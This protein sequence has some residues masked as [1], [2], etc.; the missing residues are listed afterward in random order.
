M[1]PHR[2]LLFS[3]VLGLSLILG[4]ASAQAGAGE[5]RAFFYHIHTIYSTDNPGWEM[6]KPSVAQVV[7][8]ADWAA[9]SMG[10]EAGV[11]IT[12]HNNIDAYFDPGFVPFGVA[13]PIK[14]EEWGGAGHAGALNFTGETPITEYNGEDRYERMVEETH[15]RGGIVIVNHPR[16]DAWETD[17]RLGV[18]GIEV[19][20]TLWWDAKNQKG[21]EWWQRL[22]AAGE[23][24]T[25]VAG[26]DSHFAFLPIE[27]PMNLV[28]C[29]SNHPDDLIEG[30][31]GGRVIILG[32]PVSPGVFPAADVDGDGE[33]DDAAVG[34]AIEVAGP[35]V[36]HFRVQ[37]QG[38]TSSDTL[39]LI[40]KSGTFFTGNVGQGGGWVGDSYFFSREYAEYERD[41]IRAELRNKNNVPH[42]ITNP[43]YALGISAP[44]GT[45]GTIQGAV[46]DKS[47]ALLADATVTATPGEFSKD[48]SGPDGTYSIVLPNGTYR[49]AASKPGYLTSANP[50]VVVESGVVTV[51]FTLSAALCGTVPDSPHGSVGLASVCGTLF[52]LPLAAIWALRR[53]RKRRP[54][55]ALH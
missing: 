5:F 48:V 8:R 31:A 24:L 55:G 27:K 44:E 10:L 34:D 32:A 42:C 37:V 18:D 16:S 47:G 4:L 49:V 40:D 19:W 33:Y 14:G 46:R 11:A 23:R 15:S 12:D 20:N 28:W 29:E 3:G 1:R 35:L 17:R 30:I 25:A 45:E 39:V 43:I 52:L 51:D 53:H 13:W 21:L 22:L 2:S 7:S 26:S 54:F 9:R 36:V 50:E 41:F 38:A 6:F